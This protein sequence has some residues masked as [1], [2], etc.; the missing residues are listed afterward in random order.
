MAIW[1]P[2][3]PVGCPSAVK[4]TTEAVAPVGIFRHWTTWQS[5]PSTFWKE[6]TTQ[7]NLWGIFFYYWMRVRR[8]Q[9]NSLSLPTMDYSMGSPIWRCPT[10]LLQVLFLVIGHIPNGVQVVTYPIAPFHCCFSSVPQLYFP[11]LSLPW[12]PKSIGLWL[13][14]NECGLKPLVSEVVLGSRPS[15]SWP[16]CLSLV[17][18]QRAYVADS[19]CIVNNPSYSM[20]LQGLHMKPSCLKFNLEI[21]PSCPGISKMINV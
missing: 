14:S 8:Q 15:E 17:G 12:A 6:K 11:S 18:K 7:V 3:S 10:W 13:F 1:L 2:V 5:V 19:K 21:L 4:P 9:I 20:L 16:V